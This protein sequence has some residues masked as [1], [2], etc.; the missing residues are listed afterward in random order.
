MKRLVLFLCSLFSISITG[1][2]QSSSKGVIKIVSPKETRMLLEEETI[3]FIDVRTPKEF[4]KGHIKGAQNI[5]YLSGRFNS[6]V[7]KL[8]K[9]KPVILY[10]RSGKRSAKSSKKLLNAGF[11]EIYDLEGGIIKWKEAGFETKF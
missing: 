11:A 8:D 1:C 7:E 2:K 6:E 9:T 10:C 5:D 3:Q 4:D